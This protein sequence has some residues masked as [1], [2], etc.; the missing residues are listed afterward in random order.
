M[1]LKEVKDKLDLDIQIHKDLT[2][3]I[4]ELNGMGEMDIFIMK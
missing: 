1:V 4:V 3:A 2:V